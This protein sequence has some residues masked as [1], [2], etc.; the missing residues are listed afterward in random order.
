MLGLMTVVSEPMRPSVL[1]NLVFCPCSVNR[2]LNYNCP[3]FLKF[4]TLVT[5][6]FVVIAV[7]G[8][9]QGPSHLLDQQLTLFFLLK[10]SSK[11]FQFR[12]KFFLVKVLGE[13]F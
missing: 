3:S 7:L 9:Q 10:V 5:V 2:T 4:V 1:Y 6:V 12:L 13:A 11:E 8:L